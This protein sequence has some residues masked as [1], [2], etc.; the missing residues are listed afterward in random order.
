MSIPWRIGRCDIALAVD[1]GACVNI[2]SANSFLELQKRMPNTNWQIQSP[3]VCL[4]GVSGTSLNVVGRVKLTI[5]ISK[6]S[7]PIETEFHIIKDF[8]LP[9]DGLLGLQTMVVNKIKVDPT[10]RSIQLNHSSYLALPHSSPLLTPKVV[11]TISSDRTQGGEGGKLGV[12]GSNW[13]S[14]S[15]VLSDGQRFHSQ[16]LT[17]VPVRLPD[18]KDGTDVVCISE[19][20]RVKGLSLESTLST[21]RDGGFTDILLS[22]QSNSNITLKKGTLICEFL[23]YN[24]KVKVIDD[25][26][27]VG[28]IQ[29][30]EITNNRDKITPHVKVVDYPHDKERLLDL[31]SEFSGVLA[32]P[33]EPL[34]KTDNVSH[35]IKLLEGTNPVYVPAYRFPHSQRQ[36]V[37]DEVDK[38]LNQGV[39]EESSSPWNAPIF[40]V[41]KKDGGFRPVIDYRRVN[42]VTVPDRYPLPVLRDLLQSLGKGNKVFS[43]LDLHSGFWQI[44]MGSTSREITAFSTDQGHYQFLRM[45]FGLRNAPLTFQRMINNL[46]AGLLGNTV[47]AYM[48]DLI[49]VSQSMEDHFRKL[50]LVLEKLSSAGLR[51]KLS[52]CNFLKSR[53]QFLGHIVNEEGIHTVPDK[54]KAVAEFPTPTNTDKVRSFLGL[55]GFYRAYV[56]DYSSIASPLTRLLKKDATFTWGPTQIKSFES[57]KWHLTHA[58]ILSFPDFSQPFILCTDASSLGVGAV[59]M[60]KLDAKTHTI[61][62]ASRV[63]NT[64][65]SKYSATHLETLAVVW[66]LKH[67]KDLIFGYSIT[68]Y[69]DH[70]PIREL[71]RGKNISGRLARWYLTIQEFQPEFKY[72]PGRAN[73][74]ADAL[75]RNVGAI[76][77]DLFSPNLVHTEQRQD[78]MWSRV[79]YALES[80]DESTVANLPVPLTQFHLHNDLLYKCS[81]KVKRSPFPPVYQLVIPSTLKGMVLSLVHDSPQAGHPGKDRSL[82]EARKKYFW[83]SMKKDICN[84]ISQCRECAKHRGHLPPTAPIG[85]YPTPNKPWDTVSIDLLS[86]PKSHQ[87]SNYMLV[88]VDHFSRFVVLAPLSTKS[89]DEVAHRLITHLICPYTTP[90]VLLSDNGSEFRNDVLKNICNQYN[91]AQTFVT[92]YHPASNGLVE[93]ANRK[94]LETL[95]PIVSSLQ[96]TWEDWLPQVAASINASENSFTGKSPHYIIYGYDKVL[97]YDL[98]CDSPRPLYNLDDY[99]KSQI[100]IFQKIHNEV[101]RKLPASRAE[102]IARQHRRAVPSNISVGDVV[103]VQVPGRNSKLSP[104]FDGPYKVTARNNNKV[105]LW[106]PHVSS[107]WTVHVDRLKLTD[108]NLSNQATLSPNQPSLVSPQST[109]GSDY[110][111]KLRSSNTKV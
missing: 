74:V 97:P 96:H 55:S 47:V 52:K 6:R 34:G 15:G 83:I 23:V 86:L 107:P 12:R 21:V 70:A 14:V 80:G 24:C 82:R 54:I 75:S 39:I 10:N 20:L 65:E 100:A 81:P 69:T 90:K 3:D 67:F 49:V 2:L 63:L 27:T 17:K 99:A 19:S 18:V 73:V 42:E 106:G 58:P 111:L 79:I 101:R 72:L 40:L 92:A 7:S 5:R 37:R 104:K 102:M 44:G 61:A 59:L 25:F 68:V 26:M 1:T 11:T 110:R 85:E 36:A 43:N 105:T 94:I 32:L 89:A 78:P 84:H 103:M 88:C 91:I 51:L 8:P 76:N 62:Y 66:A 87:G 29:H 95:R 45:P 35:D 77:S 57:L 4:R 28:N 48:D 13:T 41:P 38:M 33:G 98:L 56:K 60:Q 109:N 46:F 50:T 9:A 31:L 30:N 22:N 53:L 71:F 93:R 16:T 64:A 108:I